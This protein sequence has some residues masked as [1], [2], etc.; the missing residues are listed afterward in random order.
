M[1]P[2]PLTHSSGSASVLVSVEVDAAFNAPSLDI[3][4]DTFE[5]TEAAAEA[6]EAAA[7]AVSEEETAGAAVTTAAAFSEDMEAM[8]VKT[9][10]RASA[11]RL[12][13][14]T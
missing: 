7:A 11:M 3:P 10:V 8:R 12:A 4:E 1:R 14:S 5:A 13:R 2:P 6:V 9:E